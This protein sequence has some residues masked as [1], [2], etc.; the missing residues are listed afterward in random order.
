M[1]TIARRK[2]AL[3][4]PKPWQNQLKRAFC[5]NAPI[6]GACADAAMWALILVDAAL[7]AAGVD[8]GLVLFVHH[9]IVLE[10]PEAEA[11]RACTIVVDAMMRA[12]AETFP[13]EPLNGLVETKIATAWGPREPQDATAQPV[14]GDAGRPDLPARGV[15]CPA[16]GGDSAASAD[17]PGR[18]AG[19]GPNPRERVDVPA[20]DSGLSDQDEDEEVQRRTEPSAAPGP[21]VQPLRRTAVHSVQRDHNLPHA[22][23]WQASHAAE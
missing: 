11:E 16:D 23:C 9:E 8:G 2:V 17:Q 20:A 4:R 5:C 22:G 6:Q 10:V 15:P 18:A 14:D 3:I 7:S 1:L 21:Y 13:N 19:R 12:F